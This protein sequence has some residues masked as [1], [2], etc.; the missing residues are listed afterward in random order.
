LVVVWSAQTELL[1]HLTGATLLLV[2][3]EPSLAE[4]TVAAFVEHGCT[5]WHAEN[6]A[7]ARAML[8]RATPDAIVLDLSLPDVDGLVLCPRLCVEGGNAPIIVCGPEPDQRVML[9]A[10]RLGAEDFIA[11]PVDLD[12]LQARVAV[13]VRRRARREREPVAP[14]PAGVDKS[15]L[16]RLSIDL[17]GW[18]VRV[19]QREVHLSPTEFRLLAYFA[20]RVGAIVSREQLAR[21]VWGNE[22]MCSSRTIDAYLRRLR[23]KLCGPGTPQ[24]LH[25][26]GFGYQLVESA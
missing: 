26:R 16:G 8:R 23:N 15:H 19:D 13:A 1:D 12:E 5:V 3:D 18:R 2:E 7:D 17:N 10:F 11:K 24:L 25:V 6:G 22:A 14:E 21:E 9:L 4:P 20:A